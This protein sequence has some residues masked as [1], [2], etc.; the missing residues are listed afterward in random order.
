MPA[1]LPRHP[2]VPVAPDQLSSFIDF[3]CRLADASG[4][5]I[6]PHFRS[7]LAVDNKAGQGAYDPVTEADRAAEDA[8]RRLI[9]EAYPDHGIYGE[10]HGYEPGSSGLTWVID[11]IDGTRAFITGI[12]LWGTLI[13]L[14]DGQRPILGVM[15]QPFT[16][17][18][19]VGSG[20]GAQL[21]R[22]GQRIELRT[23]PCA[24]LAKARLQCTA[25]SMFN[26]AERLA[27]ERLS[28]QVQLTRF[29]GDCY[30]YCMVAHAGID[31]VVESGLLPYDVQALI[32]IVEAAGGVMTNWVGG[33]CG[34]GGQVIAAGDRRVH[35]RALD[36][37]AAAR[38]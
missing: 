35:Q 2:A 17:E 32:P 15:D 25:I 8:I 38:V 4:K 10:E 18:R 3:A 23:R 31:L 16:G 9:R 5:V 22:G 7:A 13:A 12:P 28:A 36:V 26:Q 19:F 29:S 34:N 33:D 37:L 1:P 6:L 20:L 11:P 27:F 30:A 21:R 24:E 14:H